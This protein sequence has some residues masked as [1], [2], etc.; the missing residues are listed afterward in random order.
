[1]SNPPTNAPGV[2]QTSKLRAPFRLYPKAFDSKATFIR[3]ADDQWVCSVYTQV[4]DEVLEAL[5][6]HA[7]LQARVE[8]LEKLVQRYASECG[9]CNGT[10]VIQPFCDASASGISHAYPGRDEPC[11]D[12]EDIR[13]ALNATPSREGV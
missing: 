5:N 8:T 13:A 11:P 9:E 6:A 12:C 3:D 2:A 7:T 4:A 10:G 1:M